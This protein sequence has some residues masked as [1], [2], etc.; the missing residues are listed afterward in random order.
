MSSCMITVF[1]TQAP[2]KSPTL[3][4]FSIGAMRSMTLIPVSNTS[5]FV[6]SSSKLGEAR[7]IG[8]L[9]CVFGASISS[10]G[11]P[12]T[13]NMRPSTH[14]PTGTEMGASVAT[15]VSPRFT[16]STGFIAIVRTDPSPSCCWTSSMSLCGAPCT[17]RASY[18]PGIYPALNSTSM[19]TQ[20][21]LVM[22]P[23]CIRIY[24]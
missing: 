14:S 5:V 2:P 3:P 7:W 24:E 11:S 21:I 16:P 17:S 6:E 15:T 18:I 19:T 22:M 10:I 13:L 12:R 9:I 4:P 20:I 8:S 23:V 1:P